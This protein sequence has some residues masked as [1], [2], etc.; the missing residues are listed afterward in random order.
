MIIGKLDLGSYQPYKIP[1]KGMHTGVVSIPGGYAFPYGDH[2]DPDSWTAH[3]WLKPPAA[4]G[5][6]S[7]GTQAAMEM[8]GRQLEELARNPDMQPT[9]VQ[10][11]AGTGTVAL[12]PNFNQPQDG[13]YYLTKVKVNYTDPFTGFA[14]VDLDLQY[15]SPGPP[16][17]IGMSTTGAALSTGFGG[18]I[19]NWC[20]YPLNAT[21]PLVDATRTGAEGAVQINIG[22]FLNPSP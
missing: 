14:R 8:L 7:A 1:D 16:R 12:S 15:V 4:V 20:A 10:F 18:S 3:I 6:F 11:Y 9:Y 13:F 21:I 22:P 2:S 19:T 17:T 5:Q